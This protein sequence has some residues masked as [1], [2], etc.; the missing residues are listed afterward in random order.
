MAHFFKNVACV[1]FGF[2]LAGSAGAQAPAPTA[3]DTVAYINTTLQKYPTLEFV[4]SG[5]PGHEQVVTVSEDRRSLIIK[6]TFGKSVE[7]KCDDVQTLTVPVFNLSLDA[8]GSWSKQGQHSS[9]FL[10]CTDRGDCFSRRSDGHAYPS[11]EN[12]WFLQV[13]APDQVSDQLKVAIQHLVG[14]LLIE[15]NLHIDGNDPFAKRAH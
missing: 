15:A 13:T 4:G 14:S 6:Q 1:A 5:C 10:G 8:L 9:F 11:A 7:G 12:Q 3:D 2:G